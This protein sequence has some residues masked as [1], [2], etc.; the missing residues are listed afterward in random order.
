MLQAIELLL[1][2]EL[3]EYHDA[4]MVNIMMADAQEVSSRPREYS[5]RAD[6]QN[7]HPHELYILYHL[8]QE[9]GDRHPSLF[10]S[11]RKWKKLLPTLGEIVGVECEEVCYT[12][13]RA[14]NYADKTDLCPR[15]TAHRS[16]FALTSHES[17]V[18]SLQSTEAG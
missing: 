3:F 15:S 9:Y 1:R 6:R 16:S 14:V 17:N 11:H 13:D 7:T 12:L 5:A 18:R 10:R 4:R 8:V 2:C